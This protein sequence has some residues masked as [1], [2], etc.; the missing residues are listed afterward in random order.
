VNELWYLLDAIANDT[1]VGPH[2]AT[3]E[4]GYRAAEVCDAIV[5]SGASGQRETVVYR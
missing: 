5:R 3:F 4:D 2:G 1:P